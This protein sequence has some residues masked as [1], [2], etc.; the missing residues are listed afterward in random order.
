M[1]KESCQKTRL[2]GDFSTEFVVN[3]YNN[4]EKE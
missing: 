4:N 3:N 1:L 2:T